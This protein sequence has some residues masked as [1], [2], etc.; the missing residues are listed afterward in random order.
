[1]A[2]IKGSKKQPDGTYKVP[3][4]SEAGPSRLVSN[5]PDFVPATATAPATQPDTA[6]FEASPEYASALN[7]FV[8]RLE[9][10]ERSASNVAAMQH[11]LGVQCNAMHE[12]I[13][14]NG[15]WARHYHSSVGQREE[16]Q[17]QQQAQVAKVASMAEGLVD[18]RRQVADLAAL[19]AKA[20]PAPHPMPSRVARTAYPAGLIVRNLEEPPRGG[21]PGHPGQGGDAGGAA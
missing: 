11:H 5:A 8:R 12:A 1:M 18:L 13:A 17:K 10:V 3:A 4:P 16:E 14:L 19:V 7:A 20:T 21:G 15:Q 9:I 6:A 2:P